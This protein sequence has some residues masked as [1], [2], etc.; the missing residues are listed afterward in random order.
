M[1][2]LHA[3]AAKGHFAEELEEEGGRR[4]RGGARSQEKG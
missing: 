3:G 1:S 2:T 4:R